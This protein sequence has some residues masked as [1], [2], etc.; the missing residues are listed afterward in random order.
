MDTLLT[1]RPMSGFPVSIGTSLA[2]ETLFKPMIAVADESREVPDKVDPRTY[3]LYLFNVST[4]LR[5]LI[6]SLSWR[7][8]STVAKKDVA[9]A[10]L[11]ELEF[12]TGFFQAADLN[13]K[14]Y[15]NSYSYALKTYPDKIRR[16]T[17]PQ[18]LAVV[19]LMD[20]CTAAV[21]KQDDVLS[22]SKDL[23]VQRDAKCLLVSHVPW[24]LLSWGNFHKLDLLESHTGRIKTRK[25]WNTKYYPIKDKDFSFLPFLE[26]LLTKLG[27]SVMFAPAPLKERVEL[28]EV[29]KKKKVHPLMSELSL[30][31]M[32]GRA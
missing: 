27:D 10:F 22:F 26:F 28:W 17:T 13:V 5:N 4:V 19:Q 32:M 3:D 2:L 23:H 7:D 15:W 30:G 8:M 11:E 18:Q 9:D 16:P 25:D 14:F 21:R 6:Q 12:L 24:D 20:Y 1:T 31:F 29:M